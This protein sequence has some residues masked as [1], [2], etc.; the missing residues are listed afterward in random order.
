[1]TKPTVQEA[2]KIRAD[3]F[4]NKKLFDEEKVIEGHRGREDGYD[5]EKF[6]NRVLNWISYNKTDYKEIDSFS[7]QFGYVDIKTGSAQ[8]YGGSYC[9][10]FIQNPRTSLR[11]KD[12]LAG[13]SDWVDNPK[14]D[15]VAYLDWSD[16]D[17]PLH[18]FSVN[19][20]REFFKTETILKYLTPQ[21]MEYYAEYWSWGGHL[22]T[23]REAYVEGV[24]AKF[25]CFGKSALGFDLPTDLAETKI[26]LRDLLEDKKMSE[27]INEL[28]DDTLVE[29]RKAKDMLRILFEEELTDEEIAE[30]E[31]LSPDEE[32][33]L[34]MRLGLSEPLKGSLDNNRYEKEGQ[35]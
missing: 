4:K 25:W 8:K 28:L 19:K 17:F 26:K 12:I 33:V 15:Y 35:L 5:S 2:E 1:M 6:V 30:I 3:Y 32:K 24:Q 11:E 10:E 34:R 31:N 14:I 23:P 16:D 13:I 29:I 7:D 9:L 20:L 27:D 22:A 18:L 21:K